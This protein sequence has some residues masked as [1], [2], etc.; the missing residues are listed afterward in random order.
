MD[1]G[2][3]LLKMG[4]KPCKHSFG[5]RYGTENLFEGSNQDGS[6]EEKLVTM[7]ELIGIHNL[8]SHHNLSQ[9]I[10]AG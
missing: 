2:L 5:V 7:C 10:Y 9:V 1:C 4:S 3:L 8:Q 6:R